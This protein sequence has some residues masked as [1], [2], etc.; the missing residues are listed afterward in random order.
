MALH[1]IRPAPQPT[2]PFYTIQQI[3]QRHPAFTVRTLRHWIANGKDRVSWRGRQKIIIPG[4]GFARV[5]LRKGRRIFIDET[6]FFD[7]LRQEE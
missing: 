3:S 6:A 5:I 7:W 2:G 4:N 1:Q